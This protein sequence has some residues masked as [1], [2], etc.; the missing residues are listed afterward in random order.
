MNLR[1]S[2]GGFTLVEL[3]IVIVIIGV[4][5]TVAVRQMGRSLEDARHEHTLEEL[6]QLAKAI[7][8][9]PELFTGGLRPDF[10]FVGDIGA[11]P[12]DLA[13]LVS[14]TGGWMTW[15]GPYIEAGGGLI[16]AWGVAYSYRGTVITSTGSGDVID[17][18]FAASP[19]ELL[20]NAV[21]GYIVDADLEAPGPVFDD[22]L[23]LTLSHPDGA[24]GTA[25]KTLHPRPDGSF[26]FTGVPI[27]NHVL[28][29]TC[30]PDTDSTELT[31]SVMPGRT[32][33]VEFILPTDLW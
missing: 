14:N 11:L 27:G 1:S 30:P 16:D 33:R 5:T 25:L 12:P 23:T 17:R 19:E 21:E 8:G 26:R 4:L 31:V 32:A 7:R 3:V 13:A 24:G 29:A 2:S 15:Q 10:G 18:H 9:N 22:S 20:A 6:D 28:R